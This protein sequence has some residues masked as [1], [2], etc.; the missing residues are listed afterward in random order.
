MQIVIWNTLLLF[1]STFSSGTCTR[2]RDEKGI[3]VYK[4]NRDDEIFQCSDTDILFKKTPYPLDP[5]N[6]SVYSNTI[7]K[8]LNYLKH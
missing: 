1:F 6:K 5:Y 2:W 7:K 4:A 8:I 3:S